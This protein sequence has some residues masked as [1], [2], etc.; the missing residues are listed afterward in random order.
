[1]RKREIKRGEEGA[2]GGGRLLFCYPHCSRKGRTT[3]EKR[4]RVGTIGLLKGGET[5]RGK[6]GGEKVLRVGG[7][8]KR[9]CLIRGYR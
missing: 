3:G 5:R 7:R 8:T 2:S 9:R 1:L 4:K 6:G